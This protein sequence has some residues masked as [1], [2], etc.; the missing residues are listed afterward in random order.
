MFPLRA[1]AVS[2]GR[3]QL[4]G[5]WNIPLG[6]GGQEVFKTVSTDRSI[7]IRSVWVGIDRKKIKISVENGEREI[8]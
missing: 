3:C 6:V 1:L 7:S 4:E 5:P 8:E 2:E